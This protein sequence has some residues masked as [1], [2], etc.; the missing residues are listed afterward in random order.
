M[1]IMASSSDN[2]QTQLLS[3]ITKTNNVVTTSLHR[4]IR[5]H[6]QNKEY[7]AKTDGLD[8]LQAKNGLMIS[9]LIDLTLL[10]RCRLDNNNG[11]SSDSRQQQQECLER[12]LEMKTALEKIRP[13]EKRMRYQIDKLLAL[14][15]LGAGTFA[16]VGREL[17][18]DEEKK[19]K[20]E[21]RELAIG[22]VMA[23][24]GD[25]EDGGEND[26]LSFKPDLQGMMKMFA[27]DDNEQTNDNDS[28]SESDSEDE[29]QSF[30]PKIAIE[31]D[32]NNDT[33]S[34]NNNV[35]QPP[36]LQSVPF[37]LDN[38]K[39]YLKNERL[40]QKQQDR[41]S[42]SELTQVIRSQFTDAPEEEDARGGA[43]LGKQSEKSRKIAARDKDIEEFEETHMNRLTMGRKDKRERKKMMRE[44]MSNLGA[45]AGGLG[46]IAGGVEDA[47]GDDDGGRF[48]ESRGGDNRRNNSD[49]ENDGFKMKGMRKRK[50]EVLDEGGR[51]SKVMTASNQ[52][53]FQKS[54][55]GGGGG[56]DR[57]SGGRGGDVA[58]VVGEAKAVVEVVVVAEAVVAVAVVVVVEVAEAAVVAV[59][60]VVV[61]VAEAVGG[62]RDVCVL[63]SYKLWDMLQI[64]I[65]MIQWND[66]L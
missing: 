45:I 47:F 19:K 5:H 8:F 61:E 15:T 3:S 23:N 43:M 6:T 24:E 20:E 57:G 54:L 33:S 28:N 59:A 36:R 27:E 31:R 11:S 9:Y 35:Y 10:L 46:S 32:D 63:L 34:N 42:R 25:G 17:E 30:R 29:E 44:E 50:V 7:D 58:E 40:R 21:E 51:K 39:Q 53:T 14:S 48:R 49:D 38:D 56:G 2:D 12:L 26:P 13:L 41:A 55:Y 4:T 37:E 66:C 52:N 60:V 16:A 65:A 62:T 18:E 64:K 1:T 22:R